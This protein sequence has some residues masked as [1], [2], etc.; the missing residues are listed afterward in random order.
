M[1]Q[2][3]KSSVSI[4]PFFFYSHKPNFRFIVQKIRRKVESREIIEKIEANRGTI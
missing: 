4:A 1:R 3:L 2:A